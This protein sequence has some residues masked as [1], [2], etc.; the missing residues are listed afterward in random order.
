MGKQ[1]YGEERQ[2]ASS[3]T[4]YPL[5]GSPTS[6]Q[7]TTYPKSRVGLRISVPIFVLPI[8]ISMKGQQVVPTQEIT[9][10][11]NTQDE[12]YYI[13]AMEGQSLVERTFTI[14][15]DAPVKRSAKE[16]Q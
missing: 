12:A 11:A 15:I 7:T 14:E 10:E 2:L 9:V 1:S 5:L 16:P 13:A 3:W 6:K 4:T 8:R